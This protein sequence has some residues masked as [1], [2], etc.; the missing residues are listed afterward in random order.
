MTWYKDLDGEWVVGSLINH[1]GITPFR[2]NT[3]SGEVILGEHV[4]GVPVCSYSAEEKL[5]IEKQ[6]RAGCDTPVLEVRVHQY[7]CHH[8]NKWIEAGPKWSLGL[9]LSC[10]MDRDSDTFG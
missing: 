1:A 3:E 2:L 9:C 6:L 4:G 8:C 5:Q 7:L 10:S